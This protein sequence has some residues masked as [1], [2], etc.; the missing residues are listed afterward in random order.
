MKK[1]RKLLEAPW[2]YK[3]GFLISIFIIIIGV[4]IGIATNGN[5]FLFPGF[6]TN[7][8]LIASYTIFIF[9]VYIFEK[10]A[11]IVKWIASVPAAI[12]S[13]ILI[14]VISAILGGKAS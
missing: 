3:E 5:H 7:L 13:T 14:T 10:E 4:A 11:N 6:P 1:N 2:Q 12:T 8:G 9:L